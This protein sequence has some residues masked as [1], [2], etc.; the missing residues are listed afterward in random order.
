MGSYW[1]L[2]S[3]VG[4]QATLPATATVTSSDDAS[5]VHSVSSDGG[6]SF[7]VG[8]DSDR[9]LSAST[10][11]SLR[12][13]D[14][15][16]LAAVS[17]HTS[18]SVPIYTGDVFGFLVIE[19]M[20]ATDDDTDDTDGTDG[21]DGCGASNANKARACGDTSGGD[22]GMGGSDTGTG[23]GMGGH[24]KITTMGLR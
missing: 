9:G 13:T 23:M 24:A 5:T 8:S 7:T 1:S 6:G 21:A 16:L 15:T 3:Y 11:Y 18:C 12:A 2:T 17:I 4:T 10:V 19:S 22:T 20:V 14:G